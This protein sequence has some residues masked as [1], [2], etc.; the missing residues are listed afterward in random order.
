M[1]QI[2]LLKIHSTGIP[3]EFD[4]AN[5][6]ITLASFSVQGGGPV[7]DAAGLD[8]NN[9]DIIDIKDVKFA[10]SSTAAIYVNSTSFVADDMMFESKENAMD[11]GAAVL[12]PVV[13]DDADQLDALRIPAIAG[14]PTA[15]PADGG[16]G[17]LVFDS[18][19]KNL[20][21]WDGA[22]WDNLNTVSSAEN[23]QDVYT[24][25]EALAAA[26]AVYLSA[27]DTVS[28]AANGADASS[29][30]LGFA[31]GSAL[32][33][34]PVEVR[35]YGVLSGFTSL[36]PAARYFLGDAGAITATVPSGAG[37]VI[38]Q[39]GYAKNATNLDIQILQLGRR[40]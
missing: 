5:D 32:S 2:K 17:Y 35:K 22:E 23:I 19:N 28:K 14:I 11:V 27:A 7:L 31:A 25:G 16:S 3:V 36:T 33:A 13:T 39:A 34:A 20:Y 38:V 26:E 1:A 21:A 4:S 10:N 40:A 37:N 24:A 8:L 29:R 18:S 12:F 9:E 6:E 30:L 15:T